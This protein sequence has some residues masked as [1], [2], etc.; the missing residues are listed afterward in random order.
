[1]QIDL[2]ALN[3]EIKKDREDGLFPICVVGVAGTT[4]TGAIDDL[5]G[6][7]NI[8][9]EEKL[10]FHVD[11][12]FGAWAAISDVQTPRRWPGKS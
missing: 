9:G 5:E 12:A 11:G 6:L 1:M 10:W 3:E 4:N 7:A 2:A 8:C